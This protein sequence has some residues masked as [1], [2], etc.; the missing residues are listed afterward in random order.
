MPGHFNPNFPSRVTGVL[1]YTT[2]PLKARC[3]QT[4]H[5]ASSRANC[6][7]GNQQSLLMTASHP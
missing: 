3:Q 2:L 4:I 5:S 1:F 6:F 7:R